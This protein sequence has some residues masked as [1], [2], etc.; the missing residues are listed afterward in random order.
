MPRSSSASAGPK[1]KPA[2][3][4]VSRAAAPVSDDP[5]KGAAARIGSILE[6]LAR[7]YPAPKC[8]L[9]YHDPFQLLVATILS[10]QCT[11]ERVNKVTATLFEKYR[12][13]RD[14]AGA[15]QA[16]FENDIRSTGFFRNKA[17]NIISCAKVLVEKHGG[18]VPRTLEELVVLPGVGRKTA[19]VVLGTAFGIASGI[20]VDTHVTRLSWRLGLTNE[21]DAEKIEADLMKIVPKNRWI[22]FSH[23]IILHGRARCPARSP[24]CAGCE[25]AGPCPKRL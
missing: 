23:A 3:E 18:D 5:V 16:V 24:D 19:N 2:T 14:F 22:D 6:L 12:T 7:T 10:A 15:D 25:L 17:K 4:P 1:H 21:T 20:V 9:T 8:A 13:T 11:D